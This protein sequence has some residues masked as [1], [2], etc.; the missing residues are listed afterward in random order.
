MTR[1][2]FAI[3]FVTVSAVAADQ[4]KP[5]I[6]NDRVAVWD[7]TWTKGA[8]VPAGSAAFDTVE[9]YIAGPKKAQAVFTPRGGRP[10]AH[11]TSDSNPPRSIF[12]ELKDHPVPPVANK[13]G[14]P[15][16]FPRPRVKKLLENNRVVVWSY[17]WN[18]GEPTPMHFHDKDV[19]V[20]YLEA[21]AL[22][23]TTPDGKKVF[24][25]YKSGETRFN[26]RDRTHTEL[27]TRGT[28]SAVMM[29]LK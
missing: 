29:E 17:V 8:S 7:I 3:L 13:T 10:A 2:L 6:D 26:L 12:I 20:T 21:T 19:V 5:I 25:E 16:A 11:E 27:L 28:G 23:S 9:M 15:N 1:A 18:P 24:N 4:D 14:Y 22:T